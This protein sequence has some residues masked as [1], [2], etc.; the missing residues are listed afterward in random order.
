M[1]PLVFFGNNRLGDCLCTTPT[2]RAYRRKYPGAHITYVVQNHE[3][4]RV[5]ELNPDINR[6]LYVDDLSE[7]CAKDGQW[8]RRL[9][10][11]P[12]SAF[13]HF[14]IHA[15]HRSHPG[16]FKEHLCHG[17]ARMFDVRIDSVRPIVEVSPGQRAAARAL[18][19]G[20]T[21]VFGMHTTSPVVGR[22][23]KSALKDWVLER[24]LRLARELREDA[25]F[26]ILAVGSGNDQRINS[27]YL[28]NLYGLPISVTAALLAEAA[29]VVTVESGLSHL[30]HAVDAPMVLIF[31]RDV[32]LEWAAPEE[33]TRCRVI[34]DD[35]RLVSC[36][37]VMAAIKSV[38][39][40]KAAASAAQ[41]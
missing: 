38:L 33:A 23:G 21:I 35:T 17:F 19:A 10:V 9:G 26:E 24:W 13:Y 6:V 20:P 16:V 25:G 18:M 7:T 39:A 22:D 29:C 12:L 41:R 31:S 2:V 5:L 3:H 36:E 11:S 8:L 4:C 14:D 40:M 1:R 28:R 32:P 37:R 15:L 34:Y 27:R 30:C